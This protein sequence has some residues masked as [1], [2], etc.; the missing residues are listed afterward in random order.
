MKKYRISF[1]LIALLGMLTA[2]GPMYNT[3]YSY[4]PPKSDISKM[5]TANCIQGK[6][7]CQQNCQLSH[8]DCVLRAKQMAFLEFKQYK[9]EQIR[10]RMLISRDE[11]SFDKSYQCAT[12]CGCEPT[13]KSCYSACGGQVLE[14]QVCVAFCDKK[15]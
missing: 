10:T 9:D 8:D 14:R 15:Q 5:C 13:F 12:S 2:C 7:A 3:E 1:I 4:I 6:N 11:A